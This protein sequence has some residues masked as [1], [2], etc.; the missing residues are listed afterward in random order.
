MLRITNPTASST[1][2]QSFINTADEHIV[3][4]SDGDK[5]NLSSLSASKK[6]IKVGYL[7]SKGVKKGGN[8][9]KKGSG[10]IKKGVKAIRDFNYLTLDTKK[11]FNHL[12]HI[13]T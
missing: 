9:P 12:W 11:V 8:N 13:F 5:T 6:S 4:E 2:S 3:G 10:N 1:I 7:T